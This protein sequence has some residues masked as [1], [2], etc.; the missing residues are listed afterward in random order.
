MDVIEVRS[1]TSTLARSIAVAGEVANGALAVHETVEDPS[2][3]VSN[4][5]GMLFGVGN[6]AKVARDGKG[7]ASIAKAR[8]AM[9]SSEV[10]SFGS[11]F[12]KHDAKLQSVLK[13]CGK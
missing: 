8:A 2:S 10:A 6:I 5:I 11:I 13:I 9:D 1:F 4:I 7:L 12:T 3:A